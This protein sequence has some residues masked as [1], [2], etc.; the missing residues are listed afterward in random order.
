MDIIRITKSAA[1]AKIELLEPDD[2]DGDDDLDGCD[3]G[4]LTVLPQ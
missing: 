2:D 3:F 1:G 4:T